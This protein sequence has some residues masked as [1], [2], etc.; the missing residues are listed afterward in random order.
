MTS[1]KIQKSARDEFMAPAGNAKSLA[2]LVVQAE[3]QLVAASGRKLDTDRVARLSVLT[4]MA[5]QKNPMLLQATRESLFWAFLDAA[6]CGLEWDGESGAL[7]PFRNNKAGTVE[8]QFLPMYRGLIHLAA[9]A[10]ICHDIDAVCVF[11]GDTFRVLMGTSRGIEHEPDLMVDRTWDNLIA[12]YAVFR[13][14]DG[15]VKFDVMT[16]PEIEQ[17]RAVSRARNGPWNEWPLEMAKK[18]VIKHGLKLLPRVS[19]QLRDAVEIDNRADRE[20]GRSL[21]ADEGTHALAGMGPTPSKSR[22][23][24]ALRGALGVE[25]DGMPP[26]VTTPMTSTDGSATA[27]V[28]GDKPMTEESRAAMQQVVDAAARHM[29]SRMTDEQR[30]KILGLMDKGGARDGA[31]RAKIASG[32]IGRELGTLVDMSSDEAAQVIGALSW[33]RP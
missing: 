12:C 8:V 19:V 23:V 4:R 22:G 30:S 16:R 14:R 33:V 9:D 6:R 13:L 10:G 24:V 11:K 31:A 26:Q 25:P 15:S 3:Q 20:D 7:V 28:H 2:D 21:S 5:A 17:R 29:D 27:I 18:T 32:I 1:D